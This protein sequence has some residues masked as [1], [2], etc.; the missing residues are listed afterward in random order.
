MNPRAE[1]EQLLAELLDSPPDPARNQKFNELLTAHPELQDEYLD[2]MRLHA[3]LQWRGGKIAPQDTPKDSPKVEEPATLPMRDNVS[4]S[5][6]GWRVGRRLAAAAVLFIAGIGLLLLFQAEEAQAMPDIVD[7]LIAWNL[8]LAE[9][10]SREER[11]RIYQ[12]EAVSLEASLAK[13]ELAPDDRELANTLLRNG[14]KLA[15][16]IDPAA[17]AESFSEIADKLV[18]R[19]DAATRVQ[20]EER[21]VKLATTYERLT[22]VGVTANLERGFAVA[23]LDMEQKQQ[24]DR[25]KVRYNAR[26]KHFAEIMARNPEANRKMIHRPTKGHH[27]HKGKKHHKTMP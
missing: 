6:R 1:F 15:K 19:M 9:A 7:R 23:H 12:N 27:P 22:A 10:Q 5:R 21:I 17:E 26:G 25:A 8:D 2:H 16:E 24:L 20:D 4:R 11:N 18:A 13:T 3:L 14:S